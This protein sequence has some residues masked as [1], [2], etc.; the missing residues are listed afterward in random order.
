M[1]RMGRVE[2]AH[3]I[4]CHMIGYYIMD[5]ERAAQDG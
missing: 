5:A 2:D 3:R 4:V 1:F